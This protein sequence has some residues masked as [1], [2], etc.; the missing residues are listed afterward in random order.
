[1]IIPIKM[2]NIY[3]ALSFF[4]TV[5]FPSLYAAA[6]PD[7]FANLPDKLIPGMQVPEYFTE[8]I[9]VSSFPNGYSLR[10]AVVR[11]DH[12]NPFRGIDYRGLWN[13]KRTVA[14][15]EVDLRLC[16]HP[17]RQLTVGV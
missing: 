16:H 14:S 4:M 17:R 5:S 10:F 9:G 6:I 7:L 12:I 2:I 13:D 15:G 3:M 8:A 1:M 11:S